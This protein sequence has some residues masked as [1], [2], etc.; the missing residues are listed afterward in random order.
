MTGKGARALF[1]GEA[2]GHRWQRI[3]PTEKRG[4]VQSSTITVAV[5]DEAVAAAIELRARDL[6]WSTCRSTGNGGQNVQKTDSAV[7][8][9]HVPTGTHVRS[10]QGRSQHKNRAAALAKLRTR[11]T[12]EA[13][14][15][16]TAERASTRRY[17]VG[18]GMRG[19]KRRT[20]RSQDDSVVDHVTGKTWRLRD[21][22]RGNW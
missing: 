8:L 2:G 22:V 16:A 6:E 5:L 3:P 17:Q 18:S 21:Y 12:D 13:T 7:Q 9:V 10:Q 15:Q 11:L 14:T 4:R 19:D 20:I 1:E